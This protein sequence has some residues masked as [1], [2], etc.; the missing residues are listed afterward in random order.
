V[1]LLS[2]LNADVVE[3]LGMGYV[4]DMDDIFRLAKRHA[5]CTYLANAQHAVPVLKEEARGA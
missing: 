5:S 3:S 4:T 1:Y 2:R